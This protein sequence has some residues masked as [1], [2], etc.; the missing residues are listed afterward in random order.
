MLN[1]QIKPG[2][3]V[4][5]FGAGPIGLAILLTALFYF[6]AQV[7]MVDSDY[8]RLK[9]AKMVGATHVINNGIGD[10]TEKIMAL[11]ANQGVDLVIE[12][13]GFP[14]NSRNCREII[15]PGGHIASV[16]KQGERFQLSLEGQ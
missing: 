13:A 6:P 16:S 8:N 11:T 4:A 10:T 5:I 15:T 12:S 1:G 9:N 3:T 2:D 14:G 7:I